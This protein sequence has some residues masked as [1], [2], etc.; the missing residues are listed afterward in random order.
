MSRVIRAMSMH[1]HPSAECACGWRH[2]SSPATRDR[3]KDHVKRTGHAVEVETVTID[4]YRPDAPS[5][6]PATQ[7]GAAAERCKHTD[8]DLFTNKR[9]RC[10]KDAGHDGIHAL[11]FDE[12]TQDSG[13]SEA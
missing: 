4:R 2:P 5:T 11:V 1:L 12:A 13:R 7:D 6:A 10:R 9:L 8:H 3:V